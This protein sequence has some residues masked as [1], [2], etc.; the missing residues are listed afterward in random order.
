MGV[1]SYREGVE[2]VI[3]L[4]LAHHARRRVVDEGGDDADE[5]GRP[6]VHGGAACGDTGR[7][8]EI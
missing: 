6:R 5:D 7:Y 3:D 4:E 8:R 2:R 1:R